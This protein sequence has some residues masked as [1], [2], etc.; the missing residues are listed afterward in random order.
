MIHVKKTQLIWA[1]A[2]LLTLASCSKSG[3]KGTTTTTTTTVTAGQIISNTSPLSGNV[4]GTM[5]AGE[6]YTLS[7]DITVPVG[8]TLLLQSGVT[9]K[10]P[11]KYDIIVRGSFISLGTQSAPNW[12]TSGDRKSTRLN[13]SH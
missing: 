3:S 10:I 6:T 5:A 12:I 13:S 8:D 7:G 4:S 2:G 11:G 9:I 1:T